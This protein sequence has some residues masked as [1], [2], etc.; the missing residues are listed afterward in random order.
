[1]DARHFLRCV[2]ALSLLPLIWGCEQ[3]AVPPASSA[4]LA[5]A[6]PPK[7]TNPPKTTAA[8]ARKTP[9]ADSKTDNAGDSWFTY[10]LGGSK[11][12]YLAYTRKPFREG[13]RELIRYVADS[14]LAIQRQGQ[15]S[16]VRLQFTSIETTDGKLVRVEGEASFGP[17]PIL[18]QGRVI[19]GN[20]ELETITRGKPQPQKIPWSDDIGG[21][22]AIEHSLERTPLKP[23][24]TRTIKK[25][26]PIVNQIVT[27]EL[28]AR[29]LETTRLASGEAKLLRVESAMT[30]ADGKTKLESVFWVDSQGRTFK[31]LSKSDRMVSYRTNREDALAE[32]KGERYDLA[33]SAF[34]KLAKP[35]E[36]PHASKRIRYRVKLEEDDPSQAFPAGRTQKVTKIDATTCEV[37]VRALRPD[38]PAAEGFDKSDAAPTD[39]DK[40]PN[41][42]VQSDDE[43]VMDIAKK[44]A[45]EEKDPWLIAQAL[46]KAVHGLI[47]RKNFSQA[48]GSAADVARDPQGDCTEHAVLLAALARARG[49]PSRVAIGLVYVPSESAFGFHMW[50]ELYIRDRWVPLDATLGRGGIGAGHLKLGDTSLK[51]GSAYTSFLPV[52]KVLGRLEISPIEVDP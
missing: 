48:F 13:A 10:Y 32:P 11:L 52:A 12:G 17:T 18:Y 6:A 28:T 27:V 46:E 30:F 35:L 19:D 25:L 5:Q 33:V 7:T 14:R 26:E 40:L 29:D 23:G 3:P 20:L 43:R 15:V 9:A 22:F 8:P 45:P 1:M 21:F 49:I 36:A 24:E 41:S 37:E 4:A 47:D 42:L 34:V 31:T 51:G 39:D 38:T 16:N 2:G 50:N 44:A